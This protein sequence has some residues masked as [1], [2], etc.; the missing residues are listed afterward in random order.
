MGR[1][2]ENMNRNPFP[3]IA[4]DKRWAFTPSWDTAL[5]IYSL[6][7]EKVGAIAS[8]AERIKIVQKRKCIL[9]IH[10]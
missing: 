7:K 10:P 1:M 4:R 6:G 9:R 5:L 8:I 3:N 2:G